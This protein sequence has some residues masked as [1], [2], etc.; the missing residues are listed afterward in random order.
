MSV[1]ELQQRIID[2]V[3]KMESPELLEKF[4]KLL[5]MEKEEYVYQLSEERKLIIREAQAEY[6]A[7]KYITQEELDKELDEW[8][9]E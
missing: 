1:N 3:L 6:K 2:E 4:Y 9:E 5:E 7:G 8:L